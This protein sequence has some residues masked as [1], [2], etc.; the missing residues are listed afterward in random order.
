[1]TEPVLHDSRR[2]PGVNLFFDGPGAVLDVGFPDGE[3]GR[4]VALWQSHLAR[5]LGALHWPKAV[6]RVRRFPGGA[7]LFFSAPLDGLY[8]ATEVNEWAWHAAV[9]EAGGHEVPSTAGG[10]ATLT[11]F[12]EREREPKLLALRAAAQERGL[13]FHVDHLGVS[14]GSGTGVKTWPV[15]D[16]RRPEAPPLSTVRWAGIRDVPQVLVTGSNGKTTTVRLLASI[17][18]AWGRVPGSSS[19]DR[20]MVGEAIVDAG[21]WSGPMGARVVLRDPRVEV[22]I[23]ETARGGILRRGLA[24]TRADAAIV[25]N[26]AEDHFGEWGITDLP[27][28]AETKL[29]VGRVVPRLVV[30]AEDPV[31]VETLGR[32]QRRGHIKATVGWFALDPGHALVLAARR[33]NGTVAV[34]EDGDLVFYRGDRRTVVVGAKDVPVT[35]GGVA[36]F[37]IAN[38]LGAILLASAIGIHREAI[39]AGLKAFRGTPRENP[40]RSHLFDF[41][42]TVLVDFAHNPHGQRALIETAQAMPAQRKAIILGQAGD[43]DDASIRGLARETWPWRPDLVVLK[44]M[45][46]HLR[47]RQKGE[48]TGL[49]RDE[50]LALGASERILAQADSELEAVRHALAWARPGDLV[51]LPVHA[52]RDEVL[53]LMGRLVGGGWWGGEALPE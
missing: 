37:N 22:A 53:A 32:E 35:L 49:L 5:I 1:M 21:D 33:R 44:E 42:A 4:M 48:A 15:R 30:N 50:F 43:R 52:Q 2:L 7:S 31:L 46:R 39:V 20:I 25:T 28:I 12:I 11:S 27:G 34:L 29:V 23:L 38:A 24:V 3:G 19:T 51:L 17:A 10:V 40:G 9:A 47:G 41:G 45:E 14:V 18:R 6:V 16:P 8:A 36:R 13:S 26:I